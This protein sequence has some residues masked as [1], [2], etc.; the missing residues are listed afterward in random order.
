M[1][2]SRDIRAGEVIFEEL[3]LT[4]GPSDNSRPVCLGC[5]QVLHL[6]LVGFSGIS[7]LVLLI[8]NVPPLSEN[9]RCGGRRGVQ[10]RLRL[11]HVL[12][13]LRR[14]EGAQGL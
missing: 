5:Y 6:V 13:E 11:P 9:H 14:R 2:A 1:V 4:F 7:P 8:S 12:R 3:P 10:G